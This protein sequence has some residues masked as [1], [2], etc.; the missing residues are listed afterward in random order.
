MDDEDFFTDDATFDTLGEDEL[1]ALEDSAVKNSQLRDNFVQPPRQNPHHDPTRHHQ[2]RRQ[3]VSWRSSATAQPLS[4]VPDAQQQH[5]QFHTYQKPAGYVPYS[6]KQRVIPQLGQ[7]APPSQ[8][9]ITRNGEM[10][11]QSHDAPTFRSPGAILPQPQ[12]HYPQ[13]FEE[14]TLPIMVQ[15]TTLPNFS[16]SVSNS[17]ALPEKPSSDYGDFDGFAETAELWDMEGPTVIH[18][19]KEAQQYPVFNGGA[20]MYQQPTE[21]ENWVDQQKAPGDG[22]EDVVMG[23][24]Q[25]EQHD[26]LEVAHPERQDYVNPEELEQ[27]RIQIDNVRI[28]YVFTTWY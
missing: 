25:Y 10:E 6:Q 8:T 27:L 21:V 9:M 22:A 20:D 26:A 24:S 16:Y 14:P 18:S 11:S 12:S 17:N 3:P 15:N 4:G 5:R 28:I 13:R 19:Q 23:N 1:R 7:D 2:G